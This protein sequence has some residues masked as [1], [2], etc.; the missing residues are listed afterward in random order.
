MRILLAV[1]QFFPRFHYGTETYTLHLARELIYRGHQVTVLSTDLTAADLEGNP[2]RHYSYEGIPVIAVDLVNQ[3]AVSFSGTYFRPDLN[4]I[5]RLVLRHVRPDVVH[6]THLLHL[7]VNLLSV[8]REAGTVVVNTFT[9]FWGICFTGQMIELG[10]TKSCSGPGWR[11]SRCVADFCRAR[12]C[13]SK[14]FAS[15]SLALRHAAGFSLGAMP[16]KLRHWVTQ[17]LDEVANRNSIM[18]QHFH[19]A[20]RFWVPTELLETHF[21][22]QKYDSKRMRRLCWGIQLPSTREWALRR[23]R[24]TAKEPPIRFGYIGQ[25]APHKGVQLLLDA[26]ES[27]SFGETAELRF[28]GNTKRDDDFTSQIRQ[29]LEK[30]NNAQDC[31][32]FASSQI[33]SVL[34]NLDALIIPSLWQEN[35]PLV[36]LNALAIGLPVFVADGKGLVEFVEHQ[37][38][39]FVHPCGNCSILASQ[40]RD[41]VQNKCCLPQAHPDTPSYN[42]S[43]ADHVEIIEQD[44]ESLLAK[45]E[46]T[47]FPK[48]W[49]EQTERLTTSN[50][51]VPIKQISGIVRRTDPQ[52]ILAHVSQLKPQFVH[53]RVPRVAP[54]N[55]LQNKEG[56]LQKIVGSSV[57]DLLPHQSQLHRRPQKNKSHLHKR[58][59]SKHLTV[60]YKKS[61]ET[62]LQGLN[63][64]A[65]YLDS[66][67]KHYS[68][69][70]A[71]ILLTIHRNQGKIGEFE[72]RPNSKTKW[73]SLL[74][75]FLS[76]DTWVHY[77]IDVRFL[78]KS[79]SLGLVE[80]QN[81][82]PATLEN[83]M[84]SSWQLRW[85]PFAA[86]RTFWKMKVA[87]FTFLT[88]EKLAQIEPNENVPFKL[89]KQS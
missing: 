48:S 6:A 13:S 24:F 37:K 7:G 9:D 4:K 71:A 79:C 67:I 53:I 26:F 47:L 54:Q 85:I 45:H 70:A 87:N 64:S 29:H 81:S 76:S 15:G 33:Y 50:Q 1:H 57:W 3:A 30:L 43:I 8:A 17:D 27:A 80:Q 32:T 56:D 10:K 44:Y 46:R 73:Q 65:L 63:G 5:F 41:F 11:N 38:N 14:Q 51:F 19:A 75:Y 59:H 12:G 40:L 84:D 28:Y 77:L 25:V 60:Q 82:S 2:I 61:G 20:D 42:L 69:D 55:S 49:L 16:S 83:Y 39:G 89:E 23:D 72:F 52:Q 86:G 74:R 21:A 62:E 34:A 58:F 78:R 31:G 35:A 88:E 22:E 36:L 68:S 66:L 18:R